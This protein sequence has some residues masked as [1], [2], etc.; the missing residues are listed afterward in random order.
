MKS[1]AFIVTAFALLIASPLKAQ[2]GP[3]LRWKL[4]K[5]QKFE[6]VSANDS[7]AEIE[8]PMG[9]QKMPSKM[10]TTST[11]EVVGVD[12]G[13]IKIK[14]VVQRIQMSMSNPFAGE[15]SYDSDDDEADQ[16]QMTAQLAASF[17][18]LIGKE[19]TVTI[20]D[21]GIVQ[22]SD[23]DKD[24]DEGGNAMAMMMSSEM[25][26]Q[27]FF[28]LPEKAVAKGDSWNQTIETK[29]NGGS[30]KMKNKY[31]Y[32]GKAG[33][34]TKD[35]H[36]IKLEGEVEMDIE[37]SNVAM[38]LDESSVKGTLFFDKSNGYMTKAEM[39]QKMVMQIEA[40]GISMTNTS[41]STIKTTITKK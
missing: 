1:I 33:S 15:I 40:G 19:T 5:G 31:T 26:S 22:K 28:Q 25:T 9:T 20:N 35:I 18:Q 24:E 17:K 21:R 34:G 23:E 4:E 14:T 7:K 39:E 12:D 13:K 38:E 2:T 27:M 3:V 8:T 10:T 41:E 36:K 37:D 16:D 6:I 32:D 29:N 30:V 11:W